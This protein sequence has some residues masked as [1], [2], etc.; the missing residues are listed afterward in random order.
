MAKEN[1]KQPMTRETDAGLE[2]WCSKCKEYHPADLEHFYQ[3][4][5]SKTKLSSWCRECQRDSV[6]S[7]N[8][9]SD[10]VD[11]DNILVLDFSK[12]DL[13]L[14]DIKAKAGTDFRTPEM[15]AMWLISQALYMRKVSH[16]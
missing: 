7:G 9:K 2:K 14:A 16:E 1:K 15:Q 11:G 8:K 5:R 4:N 6:G 12:A 13:L 10:A 3:D